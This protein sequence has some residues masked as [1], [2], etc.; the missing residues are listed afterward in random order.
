MCGQ[1]LAE[2]LSAESKPISS[3]FVFFGHLPLSSALG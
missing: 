2:K 3:F 1:I